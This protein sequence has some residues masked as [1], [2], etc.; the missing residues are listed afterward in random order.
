MLHVAMKLFAKWFTV[1][2]NKKHEK[3]RFN[4]I[5]TLLKRLIIY[6]ILVLKQ[7][8]FDLILYIRQEGI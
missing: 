4:T 6:S 3:E 5:R 8:E 1:D 7:T 2:L